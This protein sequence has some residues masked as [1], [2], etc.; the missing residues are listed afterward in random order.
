M[1]RL[2][3]WLRHPKLVAAIGE[4]VVLLAS[5]EISL[6]VA[7]LRRVARWFGATLEFTDSA[8]GFAIHALNLSQSERRR[9]AV[10]N[11]VAQRWPLGPGGACLRQSLSA[12]HLVRSR[13]PQLRLSVG[14]QEGGEITA[15]AWVE[16]NGTAVTDPGDFAPLSRRMKSGLKGSPPEG[17]QTE[18]RIGSSSSGVD[19]QT[20]VQ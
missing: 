17:S 15:H 13:G 20:E 12:A 10:L 2:A 1:I 16:V 19:D 5:A 7:D 6:R 14:R 4:S 18:D 3:R 8:P 9:L 11:K